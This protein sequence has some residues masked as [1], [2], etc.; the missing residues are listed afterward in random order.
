[1]SIDEIASMSTV[2]DRKLA[3][4]RRIEKER[5]QTDDLVIV[6]RANSAHNRIETTIGAFSH[7]NNEGIYLK[8]DEYFLPYSERSVVR[9]D[10]TDIDGV[11]YKEVLGLR[12]AA[13]MTQ[14]ADDLL[15]IKRRLVRRAIKKIENLDKRRC[16]K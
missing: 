10:D 9:A 2:H 15:K 8:Q 5:I 12:K 7:V 6:Y 11:P 1:M 3:V 14:V 13:S 4:M 16:E